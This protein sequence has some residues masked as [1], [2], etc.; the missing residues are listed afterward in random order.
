MQT[1]VFAVRLSA[2]GSTAGLADETAFLVD[3]SFV[4]TV[5]AFLALGFGAVEHIFLQ[6]TFHTIFPS[7]DVLA[8]ELQGAYQFDDLLDRHAVAQYTGNQLGIV[9]ILFVELLRQT[10]DGDFVSA[11]VLELEV[12][13]LDT[14]FIDILDDMA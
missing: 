6:S 12:V 1:F 9:P 14:V 4:A 13:T 2:A 5:G 3:E 11:L 7:V 10:L 8:V